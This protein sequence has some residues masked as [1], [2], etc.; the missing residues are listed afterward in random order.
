MH[1]FYSAESIGFLCL[2]AY[3]GVER[4]LNTDGHIFSN[5]G[6]TGANNIL[7]LIQD[8]FSLFLSTVHI[9][10]KI[11]IR[12]RLIHGTGFTIW[13]KAK[14]T[15]ECHR[16]SPRAPSYPNSPNQSQLSYILNALFAFTATNILNNLW[17][18]KRR[19]KSF[20]SVLDLLSHLVWQSQ[21]VRG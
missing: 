10:R 4:N 19:K 5:G 15:P 6:S 17:E 11:G 2:R 1:K 16:K 14:G 13:L 12:S 21:W 7:M 8:K 20:Q 9:L 18:R 3:S